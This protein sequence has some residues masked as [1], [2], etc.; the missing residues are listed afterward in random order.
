MRISDWSSDVCSS[1]L[2]VYDGLQRV[3][4]DPDKQVQHTLRHFFE[5]FRR[6]GAAWATVQA[7]G[8]AGLYFPRRGPAGSGEVVWEQLRSE[9]RR[10]GRERVITCG[11]RG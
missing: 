3:V 11:P 7:F 6:T 1:D 9:A 5:T 10:V 8:R 4:L 2:L